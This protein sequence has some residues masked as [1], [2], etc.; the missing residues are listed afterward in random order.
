M[1]KGSRG[2][3]VGVG[4]GGRGMSKTELL[5]PQAEASCNWYELGENFSNTWAK[6]KRHVLN[7]PIN[8]DT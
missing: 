2:L 1:P 4:G 5:S 3:G 8:K 7:P 6:Q